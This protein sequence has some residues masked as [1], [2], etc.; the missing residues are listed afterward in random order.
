MAEA[1]KLIRSK[2]AL[3]N[4]LPR[5]KRLIFSIGFVQRNARNLKG[6]SRKRVIKSISPS[7]SLSFFFVAQISVEKTQVRHITRGTGVTEVSAAVCTGFDE[8]RLGAEEEID[9]LVEERAGG[10]AVD[11]DVEGSEVLA[12]GSEFGEGV[13]M[14]EFDGSDEG[15]V[16]LEVGP[17]EFGSEGGHEF[18]AS[19]AHVFRW[20]RPHRIHRLVCLDLIL[21]RV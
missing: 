12:R 19:G 11:G 21:Q 3:S 18:A 15:D 4:F 16:G 9:A 8:V 7:L 2:S 5:F 20:D 17:A 14:G 1:E 6:Q 10:D 13:V